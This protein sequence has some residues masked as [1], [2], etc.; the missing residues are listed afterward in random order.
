MARGVEIKNTVSKFSRESA[1]RKQSKTTVE[2]HYQEW[3]KNNGPDK[4]PAKLFDKEGKE[5]K[6]VKGE[7]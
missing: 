6:R 5:I 4:S 2:Q 7:D 3:S 1:S